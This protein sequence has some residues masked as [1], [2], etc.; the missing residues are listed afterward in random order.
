MNILL[1][2]GTTEGHTRKIAQFIAQRLDNAGHTVKMVEAMLLPAGLDPGA[3]DASIVAA[4]VHVGHYQPRVVDF[5]RKHHAALNAK[6][7]AFISVSLAAAGQDD[8]DVQGIA[9]CAEAFARDTG[10]TPTQVHHVA[11][12]FRFTQYDFF[13]TWAMKYIAWRKNV[14]VVAGQDLELTDWQELGRFIDGFA[15]KVA[16]KA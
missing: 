5:A 13:K 6:P 12:A 10:W 4:S 7:A 3:Y 8:D 16:P 1:L 15:P 11:G 9:R 2:Y 14:R